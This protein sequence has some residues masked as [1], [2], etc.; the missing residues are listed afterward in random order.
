MSDPQHEQLDL[1]IR[2]VWRRGQRLHITAGLLALG[3]WGVLLFLVAVAVDWMTHMPAPGRVMILL[4][5]LAVSGYKAWRCGWRHARAYSATHTALQ[6]EEHIGGLQSLLVTAIQLR[7]AS[8]NL[9]EP[10]SE[11]YESLRD[12]TCRLF[13]YHGLVN[14]TA[15]FC[16]DHMFG[17]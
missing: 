12:V 4:T 13:G 2:A 9:S 3:R 7:T 6:I 11:V 5:L 8:R 16:F 1:R 14:G 17:F 10:G 15:A